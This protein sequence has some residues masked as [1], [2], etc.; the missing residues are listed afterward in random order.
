MV[1]RL[2]PPLLVTGAAAS[3]VPLI[4]DTGAYDADLGI[5]FPISLL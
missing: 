2:L 1:L 5:L 3:P 4:I